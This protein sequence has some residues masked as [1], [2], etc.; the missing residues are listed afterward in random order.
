MRCSGKG[1]PLLK[2]EIAKTA[3][4]V[5]CIR[6]FSSFLKGWGRIKIQGSLHL[7]GTRGDAAKFENRE[8]RWRLLENIPYLMRTGLVGGMCRMVEITAEIKKVIVGRKVI[9][10]I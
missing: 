1:P 2:R 10:E 3:M 6:I 4:R 7:L 5:I 8:D 9:E